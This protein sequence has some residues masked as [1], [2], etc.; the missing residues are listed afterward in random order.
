LKP[1]AQ[2]SIS[3]SNRIVCVLEA[4]VSAFDA[5]LEASQREADGHARPLTALTFRRDAIAGVERVTR[6]RVAAFIS[7]HDETTDVATEI[8]LLEVPR[9]TY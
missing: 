1:S 2:T 7:D 6:R 9:P 5:G 4:A 8:F 3:R